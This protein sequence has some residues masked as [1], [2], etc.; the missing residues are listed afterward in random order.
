MLTAAHRT[1][2]AR[3]LADHEH[4]VAPLH[5]VDLI[6]ELLERYVAAARWGRP[7]ELTIGVAAHL[8]GRRIALT[9]AIS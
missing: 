9:L 5:V 2:L 3:A 7:D 4:P 1:E 6:D 8:G